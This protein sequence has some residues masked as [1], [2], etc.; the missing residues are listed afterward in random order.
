MNPF[1]THGIKH[2]SA[3]SLN[4][5]AAEPAMWVLQKLAG[6]QTP[7]GYAAHRGT[8]SESG[9]VAGLLNPDMPI[10]EAQQM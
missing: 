10:V 5:F 4:T 9:I 7:A 8:A 2:L 1:E 6:K 3:S